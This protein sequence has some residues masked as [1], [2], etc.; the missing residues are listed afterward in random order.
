L[1]WNKGKGGKVRI[2]DPEGTDVSFTLHEEYWDFRRYERV[3]IYPMF[4]PQ[5]FLGHLWGRQTPPYTEKED[6]TGIIAG[7]TN[8][9]GKPYPHMKVHIEGSRVTAF[10]G[11]GGFGHALRELLDVGRNIR[12]PEYPS[13][14]LFWWWEAAIGTHPKMRRP[15]NAFMLSGAA[16]LH[17][18]LRSGVIHCGLGTP[19]TGPS[20]GWARER[21]LPY[22]HVH[23][24]LLNATYELTCRD[25]SKVTLIEKGHL[26]TL[27]DPEVMAAA[28]KYGDPNEVLRE[29]WTA[30]IPGITV[31]GDYWRDYA[32]DP[33]AWLEAHNEA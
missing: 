15:S 23:V 2:T 33:A 7:T 5:P 13:E 25:G 18:R 10:E 26:T 1:I 27:D 11:G 14:G 31:P 17:E 3:E 9:T 29:E 28:S 22:G 24:H 20:E 30:P 8:S 12:Y 21:N 16:A 6:A 32:P 19:I 4:T